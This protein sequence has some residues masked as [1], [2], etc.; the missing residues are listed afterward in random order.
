MIYIYKFNHTV[1]CGLQ[2]KT[3]EFLTEFVK[4]RVKFSKR[5]ALTG[6]QVLEGGDFFQGVHMVQVSRLLK[7]S[8]DLPNPKIISRI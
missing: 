7:F 2:Q 1:I 5:G 3:F 4:K 6:S 8:P